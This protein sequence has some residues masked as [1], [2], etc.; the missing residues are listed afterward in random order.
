MKKV[1]VGFFALAALAM[2][3]VAEA[4]Y[5]RLPLSLEVRGHVAF[6]TGDL[7]NPARVAADV[8]TGYGG[9]ADLT[10]R[11]SPLFGIY[12]GVSGTQFETKN[13]DQKLTDYG[14]DVGA[15]LTLPTGTGLSPFLRGGAVFHQIRG[16]AGNQDIP[17]RDEEVGFEVGGGIVLPLGPTVSVTP[18]VRY[19][20]F[21]A[22]ETNFNFSY[23]AAGA[24]LMFR[25]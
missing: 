15:K 10:F 18:T 14:F 1:F 8:G 9:A 24:G 6:P 25:F 4:Q 19:V 3:S 12:G 22:G 20:T 2:S 13:S 5:G 16:E 11:L 21:N 23:I 17:Y 7:A